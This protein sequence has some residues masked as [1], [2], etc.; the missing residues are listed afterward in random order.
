ME[1]TFPSSKEF[2]S[3][4]GLCDLINSLLNH[5]LSIEEMSVLLTDTQR[6]QDQ[7]PG[8]LKALHLRP[9]LNFGSSRRIGI[10]KKDKLAWKTGNYTPWYLFE[11]LV[12]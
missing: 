8:L 11:F 6:Y 4:Q 3:L 10:F 2:S 1:I 12:M 9:P 5:H 7:S